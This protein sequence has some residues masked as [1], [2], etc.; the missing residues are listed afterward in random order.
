MKI[1][2]S[3][4]SWCLV[5]QEWV[6][7]LKRAFSDIFT[8]VGSN[9]RADKVLLQSPTLKMSFSQ[10]VNFNAGVNQK[11][12]LLIWENCVMVLKKK[13]VESKFYEQ[14]FTTSDNWNCLG[15]I[16]VLCS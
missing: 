12:F 11:L 5:R 16:S 15:E 8:K 6:S 4:E 10:K 13:A 3:L 2:K 9:K 14:P 1:C 7:S